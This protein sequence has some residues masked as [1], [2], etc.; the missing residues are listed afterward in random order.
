MQ[1][2]IRE[3]IFFLVL[4]AV[5]VSSFW[6]V[7][8]PQNAEIEQAMQEIEHK[9]QM[10]QSLAEATSQT[11]D[12]VKANEEIGA[13]IEMIE[14]RLPTNKEV[15]VILEQVADIA[16]GSN[17]ELARVRSENPVQAAAY[18]EQPLEMRIRGEFSGFYSFLLELEKLDRITR[19]PNF[20]VIRVDRADGVVEANF[21]LSIYFESEDDAG[22]RS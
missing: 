2:G 17:L 9:E 3:L 21:T 22:G 19:M 16:T 10:L 14:S 8:R 12:L 18:M 1:F 15:D 13:A 6:F 5:P 4:L 7:F 20:R 11:A